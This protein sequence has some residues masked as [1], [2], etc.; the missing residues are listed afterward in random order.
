MMQLEPGKYYRTIYGDSSHKNFQAVNVPLAK[1]LITVKI[2]DGSTCSLVDI[3]SDSW[4][5]IFEV[6]KD[7]TKF[8]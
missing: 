2:E 7:V 8:E 5:D 3:L 4:I 6:V 1:H